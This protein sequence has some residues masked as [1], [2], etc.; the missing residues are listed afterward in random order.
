MIELLV[1]SDIV[2][3]S[4]EWFSTIFVV[5]SV[6]C[7]VELAFYIIGRTKSFFSRG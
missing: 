4:Q 3:S 6:I 5:V 7:G 2:S 1:L